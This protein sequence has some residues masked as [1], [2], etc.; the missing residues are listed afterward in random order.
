[1]AYSANSRAAALPRTYIGRWMLASMLDQREL[2]DRLTAT[3]NGG[4][5]VGWN[6]DE[7]AV[8]EAA[9]E[10]MLRRYYGPDGP[11]DVAVT[12]IAALVET[13]SLLLTR[14]RSAIVRPKPSSAPRWAILPST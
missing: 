3:L 10:L 5:R 7:P 1:M 9:S 13:G 12:W 14:S 11:D 2:R 6:D 4:S 8:V